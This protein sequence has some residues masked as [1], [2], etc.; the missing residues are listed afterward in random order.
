MGLPTLSSGLIEGSEEKRGDAITQVHINVYDLTHVNNYLCWSG[1]G[2]YGNRHLC[3]LGAS[4][5]GTL[6]WEYQQPSASAVRPFD[7][8]FLLIVGLVRHIKQHLELGISTAFRN[9]CVTLRSTISPYCWTC[10]L[11]QAA[12][13]V[14]NI[15][16]LPQ[17][18]CDPSVH[19]F[20]F[21][22]SEIIPQSPAE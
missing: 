19:H 14:G 20:S 12:S 1:S 3:R 4:Y 15:N 7:P 17:L 10:A 11:Y 2:I 8:P 5:P 18:L 16:S 6:S 9:Y 22:P 21:D 13:G